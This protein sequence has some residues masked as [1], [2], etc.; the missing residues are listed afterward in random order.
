MR[1]WRKVI[2]EKEPGAKLV[3][4]L[5]RETERERDVNGFLTI[6]QAT[7][8]RGS[9]AESSMNGFNRCSGNEYVLRSS[10]PT[11]ELKCTK[12]Q[13]DVRASSNSGV[14]DFWYWASPASMVAT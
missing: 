11:D 1:R 9:L 5:V 10:A 2:G 6:P 13:L 3:G 7:K 12:N 14:T 4:G 8:T